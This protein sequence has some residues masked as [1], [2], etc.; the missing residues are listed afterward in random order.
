[1]CLLL[2]GPMRQNEEH[3]TVSEVAEILDKNERTI[4]NAMSRITD[5]LENGSRI[6]ELFRNTS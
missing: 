1:M 5:K 4:K 6:Y 2:E 3:L